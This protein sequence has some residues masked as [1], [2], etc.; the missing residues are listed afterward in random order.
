MNGN[1]DGWKVAFADVSLDF[2]EADS[3]SESNIPGIQ[4]ENNF[5][6]IV[7]CINLPLP[8]FIIFEFPL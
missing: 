1:F 8:I 3:M 4:I 2:V 6:Q 5:K 7:F